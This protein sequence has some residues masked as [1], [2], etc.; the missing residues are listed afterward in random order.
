MRYTLTAAGDR[1]YVRLGAQQLR[2]PAENART[3]DSF[4]VCLR[5]KPDTQGQRECWSH[6]AGNS[7]GVSE[8]FEGS[9]VVHNGLVYVALSRFD[10][11]TITT[12]VACYDAD[13]GAPC[14][15]KPVDLC[16]VREFR[17]GPPRVRLRPP[18]RGH[19]SP[20]S[21]RR[22]NRRSACVP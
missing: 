5:R 20:P 1:V 18:R 7:G 22:S 13:S 9:P 21:A 2:P 11:A 3:T 16:E 14:W 8:F 15:R 4:L 12:A 6:R 19:R 17:P 10:G